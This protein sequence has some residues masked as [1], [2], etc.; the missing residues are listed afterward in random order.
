MTSARSWSHLGI[1]LTLF[2]LGLS[3]TARAEINKA[4]QLRQKAMLNMAAGKTDRALGQLETLA[5][6]PGMRLKA[7]LLQARALFKAKR[8]DSAAARFRKV[9]AKAPADSSYAHKARFGLAECLAQAKKFKEAERLFADALG[10]LMSDARRQQFAERF[11][12]LGDE[13]A[14]PKEGEQP[15]YG[16]AE[17]FY[18][19]A[20]NMKLSEERTDQLKLKIAACRE[21][22]KQYHPAA[23]ELIGHIDQLANE[24]PPRKPKQLTEMRFVIGRN[25]IKVRD[26]SRARRYLDDLLA[27]SPKAPQAA[28]SAFLLSRT[29][30]MPKPSGGLNLARGQAALRHFLSRHPDHEKVPQARLELATAALHLGRHASAEDGI[31]RLIKAGDLPEEQ[32]ATA[33]YQLAVS[34][35]GQGRWQDASQAYQDYLKQHPAHAFWTQAR[36]GIEHMAWQEA[37]AAEADK[38]WVQAAESYQSFANRFQ[39]ASRAPEALFKAA[40]AWEKAEKI[41]SALKV[42]STLTAKFPRHRYGY[43]GWFATGRL[44]EEKRGDFTKAKEA[45]EKAKQSGSHK[46]HQ[47]SQRLAAMEKPSLL[48]ESPE[49]FLTSSK[50]K[51]VWHVRNIKKVKVRA[52][53]MRAE[54]FFRDRKDMN[55]VTEVDIALCTPDRT[56]DVKVSDYRKFVP[57]KQEIPLPFTEPGLY[58]LNLSGGDLEATTAVLLSDLGL[59]VKT[60]AREIFVFAQ[61]SRRLKPEA[62]TRVLVSDGSRI[63]MEGRTDSQGIWRKKLPKDLEQEP[64]NLA[65]F[66]SADD[67]LAWTEQDNPSL[68]E[69]SKRMARGYLFSERPVYRPGDAVQL[70]GILRMVEKDRYIVKAGE[71]LQLQV[72]QPGGTLLEKREVTL[73]EYGVFHTELKLDK[74][75]PQG[76]YHFTVSKPKGP[77]FSASFSVVQFR[78]PEFDL[79]VVFDKPVVF[80]GEQLS[81]HIR[82]QRHSGGSVA[83]KLLRYW[84][85]GEGRY[86]TGRTDADGRIAFSFATRVYESSRQLTVQTQM[87]SGQQSAKASALLATSGFELQLKVDAH[88]LFAGQPFDLQ[89]FARSADGKPMPADLRLEVLRRDPHAKGEVRVVDQK[90]R[91]DETGKTTLKLNLAHGGFHAIRAFGLDRAGNPVV[92]ESGLTTVGKED[93]GLFV[94]LENKVLTPNSR[95]KLKLHSRLDKALVLLTTETDRILEHRSMVVVKGDNALEWAIN[96]ALAPNFRITAS[97][98][99]KDKLHLTSRVL[100]VQQKLDIEL[101]ADKKTYAPGE[102]VAL[103][104]IARNAAGQ[105]VDAQIVLAAVDRALLQTY[106]ERLA[107]LGAFFHVHRSLGQIPTSASNTRRFPKVVGIEVEKAEIRESEGSAAMAALKNKRRVLTEDGLAQFAGMA[108][109]ESVGYGGLGLSGSGRGGGG[110]AAY[111]RGMGRSPSIRMGKASQRGGAG[112][113]WR[114]FFP[115]TAFF[116][117]DVRTGPDG[118]ATVNFKLPDTITRWRVAARGITRKTQAGQKIME[119]TA[120]RDFYAQLVLPPELERGDSFAPVA[121]LVNDGKKDLETELVLRVAGTEQKA[122][123]KVRAGHS[124]EHIFNAVQVA[125]TAGDSLKLELQA[126]AGK[127]GDQLKVKVPLRSRGVREERAQEMVLDIGQAKSIKLQGDKS[128]TDPRLALRFSGHIVQFFLGDK[129]VDP[130]LFGDRPEPVLVDL[131]IYDLL[132]GQGDHIKQDQIKNRLR[133]GLAH[134]V[135]VQHHQGGWGWSRH[136]PS[137]AIGTTASGL[138]ALAKAKPIAGKIGWSLPEQKMDQARDWLKRQLPSLAPDDFKQR[139]EVL[140]ALSHLGIEQVPAVQ[141]HRMHRMRGQLD[142]GAA[143]LLGLTWQQLK[144]PEQA[145]ELASQVAKSLDFN[146]SLPIRKRWQPGSWISDLDRVRALRLLALTG[147]DAAKLKEGTAWLMHRGNSL[148]W[149]FPRQAAEALETLSKLAS[150]Q[151][152][153]TRMKVSVRVN[154]KAAGSIDLD[155]GTTLAQLKVDPSLLSQGENKV[156]FVGTGAG[157]CLVQA[158]LSGHRLSAPEQASNAP[159]K[160]ERIVEPVPLDYRGTPIA[161][162][163]STVTLPLKKRWTNEVGRI[164]AGRKLK[165]TLKAVRSFSQPIDHCVIT[166]RI[167]PGMELVEGSVRGNF[168]HIMRQG[169]RLAFFLSS[170][171]YRMELSYELAA[172]NPGE[173][174]FPPASLI[175]LAHPAVSTMGPATSLQVDLPGAK[176]PEVKATPDERFGRGIA[177]YRAKD[178]ATAVAQLEPLYGDFQLITSSANDVLSKLLFASIDLGDHERILKYFEISK[179]K[180]PN[181]VIPFDKIQPVQLA[182]RKLGVYEGGMYLA[183]GLAEAQF[184]RDLKAVGQLESERAAAEAMATTRELLGSYPDNALGAQAAYSFSQVV[185]NFAD[186]ILA[187]EEIKGFDRPGMLGEVTGF[188]AD[189]LGNYPDDPR[190][191]EA[192]FS[193]ASA[194]LERKQADQAVLWTGMGMKR[195]SKSKMAPAFAYLKAFAHFRLGEYGPSLDLCKKVVA[196]DEKDEAGGDEENRLMAQYIMAQI[197]HAR[198]QLP[199]ALKLYRKVSDRFR[200][201]AEAVRELERKHFRAPEVIEA[202]AGKPPVLKVHARN[203][204]EIDLRAYRVDLMKLYLLKGSLANLQDVNL[205]GIKPVL[206]TKLRL[207]PPPAGGAFEQ[208]IPLRLPGQGAYLLILRGGDDTI[209]SLALVDG[210]KCEVREYRGANR[211]RVTVRDGRNKPLPNSR[212][213]LKGEDDERFTAGQT[214]LRGVFIAEAIE[215]SAT[216]IVRQGKRF[217]LYRADERKLDGKDMDED[218][219][220]PAPAEK[221]IQF[222]RRSKF[223]FANDNIN[224]QLNRPSS[225]YLQ[226]RKQAVDFFNQDVK[227]MQVQQALH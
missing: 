21:E 172:V 96:D 12:V 30:G 31:R 222:K 196:D 79:G 191:P 89:L 219:P 13:L 183:R 151:A 186:S 156:E 177:A 44:L 124:A 69:S 227:G 22:A 133:R 8:F 101:R 223:D 108:K 107:D 41:G 179:E 168:S 136:A 125:T 28:E 129:G 32:L 94:D 198:G 120:R 20:L 226:Q 122:R 91:I 187:G 115:G 38:K 58:L 149:R 182:Y 43:E 160:L 97:A 164:P 111:G 141:L 76:S 143:S 78:R 65:I 213:Q 139:G 216:V 189:F 154:G 185:Y 208:D 56:W 176:D 116:R 9:L 5:G 169:R 93:P 59:T 103:T 90:V 194:F 175:S 137:P 170:A 180:N 221:S 195:H 178:M 167:P 157:P 75:A 84:L 203:L 50:P 209:Y 128:W 85:E 127:I 62:G 118:V 212:V 51:L 100:E 225:E 11:I 113:P 99:H 7:T 110:S 155:A 132:M 218:I 134:M 4:E 16:R 207:R 24:K 148:G 63:I 86:H 27:E 70:I 77:S 159:L 192:V 55:Q 73:D 82:L 57:I 206:S 88:T 152:S 188:M 25:L 46:S 66:A 40:L 47:A 135:A 33:R 142:M 61:D 95:A 29:Y 53:R 14:K 145:R 54:D 68:N 42:L 3:T 36:Q 87:V 80:R 173:Y 201:A 174:R 26:F 74:A 204:K 158:V 119:L 200:D 71:I 150:G 138:I 67:D 121:R 6:M 15:E 163:F 146:A 147:V 215:G 114:K 144:R 205:A 214:D 193:L 197:R 102:E 166:E 45:Y 81:G 60:S 123:L 126:S 199:E 2:F 19:S 224:G 34:L 211:V 217:G 220:M 109:E 162:G 23:N 131:A 39:A 83:D 72:H 130:M 18:R 37:A 165:V 106:P 10:T 104:V 202:R 140:Y 52:Y 35:A 1:F 49:N 105:P 48:V 64:D 117:H 153:K 190:V 161:S 112:I 92:V 181:L 210:L 98:L 171:G 184:L 17:I